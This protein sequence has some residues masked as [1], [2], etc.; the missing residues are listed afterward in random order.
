MGSIIKIAIGT[1]LGILLAGLIGAIVIFGLIGTAISD[2]SDDPTPAARAVTVAK[3]DDTDGD[4][5]PDTADPDPYSA[6]S[7]SYEATPEPTPDKKRSVARVTSA[8]FVA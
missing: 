8:A 1:A 2:E 6:N 4:G 7:A 5:Q 3:G